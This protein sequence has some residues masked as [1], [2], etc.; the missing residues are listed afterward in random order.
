MVVPQVEEEGSCG[1]ANK[2]EDAAPKGKRYDWATLLARVFAIDVL[3]C[4]RCG[5][6]A[7]QRVAVVTRAQ[8]VRAILESIGLAADS[9][10]AAP[11]RLPEQAEMFETG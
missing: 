11:A 3:T 6:G 5:M 4:P 9:P 8:S 7:M 10:E 1:H 2:G